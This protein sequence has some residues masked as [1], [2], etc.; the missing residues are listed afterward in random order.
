VG[1]HIAKLVEVFREVRRVLRRDGTLWLNYGD[2]YAGSGKGPTGCNGFGDAETRQGFH[3]PEVRMSD[4]FKPKDLLLLPHRLAIALQNDGWWV[5][6]DIVW[7][8]LNPMPESVQDRP[9]RSHEYV[10]LLSRSERYYYDAD[11]VREASQDRCGN[12]WKEERKGNWRPIPGTGRLADTGAKAYGCPP[13]GRNKRTVWEIATESYA[14]AHFATFPRAL[15][16]PC[17]LAGTSAEGC[18]HA[19]GAPFVMQVDRQAE[20]HKHS[21]WKLNG[22]AKTGGIG[23]N[24]PDVVRETTGWSQSCDCWPCDPVPCRVLDC[25]AGSGTVGEVALSLGRSAVLLELNEE[26]CKLIEK[27]LSRAQV[28]L[29]LGI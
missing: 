8:K 1:D 3:T 15:V 14:A 26:Y 24:F 6:S 28:P 23:K 11:A 9:T 25:F 7:S 13:A 17:I 22:G 19:C 21:N 2:A 12:V 10:F 27:R 16:R 18:C 29:A 20:N 5:R 4:G